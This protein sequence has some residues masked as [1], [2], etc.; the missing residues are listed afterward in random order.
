MTG[1]ARSATSGAGTPRAWTGTFAAGLA[2][3]AAASLMAAGGAKTG[4][5][6][7]VEYYAYDRLI[8]AKP[9]SP[10]SEIVIVDFDDASVQALNAFPI[11]RELLANLISKI[12]AGGPEL[13]GLDV[14]LDKARDPEADARLE[15]ALKRAGNVILAE[16]FGTSELPPATPLPA[17]RRV[18]FDVGFVNLVVDPD[19]FIRRAPLWARSPGY[20][21]LSFSV[22]L[23][24]NFTGHPLERGS[25]GTFHMGATVIR[26]DRAGSNAA[27]IGAWCLQRSV[28]VQQ[29]LAPSFDSRLFAGRIVLVG[30]SSSAAKD[31]YPTPMFRQPR[32]GGRQFAS[33]AEIHAAALATMLSGRG[34][35]SMPAGLFW[36]SSF[37]LA[38]IGVVSVLALRPWFGVS[39]VAVL[40]VGSFLI[41]Q[42]L[43]AEQG[44]WMPLGTSAAAIALS[45]PA[46][47]GYRFVRERRAK[48]LV[49]A[50]R[51][52]LVRL[53]ER[54]VSPDVAAE[55]WSR[56]N[57]IVLAGQER[58][59]TV[60]FS[61][62]RNFTG[63][64][65]GQPSS[66]VLAWLNEYFDA[67]S[68]V[69]KR[70]RGMLNKFI[71]DGLLVVFGL[72]LSDGEQDDARRAVRAALEMVERVGELNR[73]AR[74]G[75]P[76]LEIGIG[77]H[78]GILT[79]GNVGARDRLEY[80]VIGETV[81][82]A[83]RLEALTKEF[84]VH[85]VVS[86]RTHE[87]VQGAFETVALGEADVRGFREK[88]LLYTVH[89]AALLEERT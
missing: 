21:A 24:T 1:P 4:L 88:V 41:A 50:E 89:T 82:L 68:E 55:I 59:A 39:G 56:R 44:F 7:A 12:S 29:V 6:D 78:T 2:L 5:L 31:L 33:G 49:E 30:Q 20:Q 17:F 23:A 26:P 16:V 80:S 87:L 81:N 18:A 45:L 3:A 75:R 51:R 86:P 63:L 9:C 65:A 10:A 36:I 74:P 28:P 58:T 71:G 22:A 25:D 85:I 61:D 40:L 43:L 11:P 52:D 54:Y 64:S 70:N 32:A 67:M 19:G 60:L 76:H 15:R 53:F 48:T 47:L 37:L 42:G 46:G 77:V 57:E 79:A 38:W 69:I 66:E 73:D 14:L 27:L 34:I 62:I 13:I 84:K 35:R 8:Q 83:S 72:P